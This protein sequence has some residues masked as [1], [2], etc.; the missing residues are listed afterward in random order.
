MSQMFYETRRYWRAPVVLAR[1]PITIKACGARTRG[2]VAVYV[3]ARGVDVTGVSASFA[4]AFV[5]IRT[6]GCGASIVGAAV[7]HGIAA[8][9]VVCFALI[10]VDTRILLTT[11]DESI[12]A[13]AGVTIERGR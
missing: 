2:G 12:V 10:N 8:I 1:K 7:I 13:G 3:V 6:G 4:G 9:T 5:N 11:A